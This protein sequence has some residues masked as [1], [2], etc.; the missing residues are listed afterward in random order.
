MYL[1]SE[2]FCANMHIAFWIETKPSVIIG[3]RILNVPL[4]LLEKVDDLS[5]SV[6][7]YVRFTLNVR[8]KFVQGFYVKFGNKIIFV[9][10]FLWKP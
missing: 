7:D 6:Y 3:K 2:L 4:W 10:L 8:N 1:D 5:L 9:F